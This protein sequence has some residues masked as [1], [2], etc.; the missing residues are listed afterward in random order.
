VSNVSADFDGVP[1]PG[2]RRIR[3]KV[4]SEVIPAD[5][6]FNAPCGGGIG[7]MPAGVYP[8]AVDDGYYATI[9]SVKA[10]RHHLHIHAEGP[11]GSGFVEDITYELDV[12][13]GHTA[14]R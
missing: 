13:P 3:S 10:G 4:F 2:V 9:Q 12:V 7:A 11:S 14:N 6:V 5:N 1:V 8:L